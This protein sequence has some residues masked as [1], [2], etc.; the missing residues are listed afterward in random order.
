M[1]T[2]ANTHLP[3]LTTQYAHAYHSSSG[4]FGETFLR[5]LKPSD[6]ELSFTPTH[7]SDPV[8]TVDELAVLLTG[9]KMSSSHRSTIA[10]AYGKFLGKRQRIPYEHMGCDHY[11]PEGNF[12]LHS[13]AYCSRWFDGR[14]AYEETEKDGAC[15]Y[16]KFPG[17]TARCFPARWL[18]YQKDATILCTGGTAE[19]KRAS[20]LM[21]QKLALQ[22]ALKLFFMSSSFHSTNLDQST[23]VIR[24]KS[25]P[26]VSRG[27]PFKALVVLFLHGG[28]DSFNMLVRAHIMFGF[29][30]G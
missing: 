8:A 1:L 5:H 13:C 28:S 23:G 4:G 24:R 17:K 11:K 3:T 19:E 29:S 6:G 15:L 27:R 14:S 16:A 20:A 10:A 30:F 18:R 26:Q 12:A 7:G 22:Q 25:A 21:A 2:H 9:G